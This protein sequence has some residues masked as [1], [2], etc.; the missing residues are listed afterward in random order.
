[1][2]IVSQRVGILLLAAIAASGCFGSPKSR[3]YALGAAAVPE[4]QALASFPQ[5]GLVVGP[6]D[7]PRYLDRPEIVTRDGAHGLTVSETN[8]WAGSLRSDFLRVLAD[9]LGRRV[10]TERVVAYPNEA[11]FK[12]DYRVQ[13]ELVAFEGQ[14]GDSVALRARWVVASGDTGRALVA[15]VSDLHEPTAS[16]SWD[17]L[18]AAHG[19][20]L[21]AL[22]G[23]IAARIVALAS[24]PT[25][26]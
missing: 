4:G 2:R 12:V 1:M 3:H 19:R 14:L 23:E 5:L 8:R 13:V 16:A 26:K 18:V 25:D 11:R 9:Q 22:S 6:V 20:A 24:R 7:F 15:E 17:D 10:G 21:D